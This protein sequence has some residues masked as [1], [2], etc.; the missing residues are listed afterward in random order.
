MLT[1]L[2]VSSPVVALIRGSTR[3]SIEEM[4]LYLPTTTVVSARSIKGL[5][6]CALP[7]CTMIRPLPPVI[8]RLTSVPS[9]CLEI[10]PKPAMLASEVRSVSRGCASVIPNAPSDVGLS[11][12]TIR[13][14]ESTVI[15]V[16]CPVAA[17]S[18][19]S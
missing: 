18:F 8:L 13:P 15:R 9:D 4:V 2:T 10:R 19:S 16:Y 1:V 6:V 17:R 14:R 3:G 12:S 5:L 11:A 7:F